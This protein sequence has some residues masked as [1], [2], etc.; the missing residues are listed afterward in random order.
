VAHLLRIWTAPTTFQWVKGHD[1]NKGNEGSDILAKEGAMKIKEDQIDL[2]IPNEFDVQ[3]PKLNTL[4][5][6]ITYRG[7]KEARKAPTRR[8]TQEHL[9]RMR[10]A[11]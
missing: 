4:T 1:G 2:M 7:I 5:Q 9:Q 11:I 3:G 10:N 8:T 6:A